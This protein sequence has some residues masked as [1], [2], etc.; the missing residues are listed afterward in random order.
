MMVSRDVIG[1]V[2]FPMMQA[3]AAEVKVM[4]AADGSH[5][6]VFTD[7][8][9]GFSIHL[10]MPEKGH[11]TGIRVR[12]GNGKKCEMAVMNRKAKESAA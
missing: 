5:V 12:N 9:Y 1:K 3:C 10:D 11:P 7:G 4:T 8:I 6:F 2:H